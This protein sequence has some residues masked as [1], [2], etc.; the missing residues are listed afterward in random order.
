MR[1]S[2]I[3]IKSSIWFLYPVLAFP[4]TRLAITMH[5]VVALWPMS[6]DKPARAELSISKFVIRRPLYSKLSTF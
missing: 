1:S 3:L 2:T 4:A 6:L 5:T